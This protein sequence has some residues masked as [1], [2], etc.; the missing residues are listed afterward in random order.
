[1]ENQITL[2]RDLI[3]SE[4]EKAQWST[5]GFSW[6]RE[7][8]KKIIKDD[9]ADWIGICP[10]E[11][12][13]KDKWCA[14]FFGRFEFLDSIYY[15]LY[16]GKDYNIDELEIGKNELDSFITRIYNKMKVFI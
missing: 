4:W 15:N 6:F 10:T 7:E 12:E 16:P 5:D 8:V 9:H 14:V 13:R 1:M 2:S 3:L 11:D